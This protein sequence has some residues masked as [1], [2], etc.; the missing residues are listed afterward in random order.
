M[1][2]SARTY[3]FRSQALGPTTRMDS[4][5]PRHRTQTSALTDGRQREG[6]SKQWGE[7][8]RLNGVY[9]RVGRAQ[10]CE[11]RGVMTRERERKGR[12]DG[13]NGDV[14]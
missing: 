4:P 9:Y 6:I 11:G 14:G 1:K 12:M 10:R 2:N 5:Q 13:F 3:V 7:R 8:I